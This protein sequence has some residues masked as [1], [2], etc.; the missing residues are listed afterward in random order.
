[1]NQNRLNR[2][3]TA[4]DVLRTP[5]DK[6]YLTPTEVAQLMNVS[7]IT[8]RAWAAKGMLAAEVTPGG[9][10]RFRRI[11]VERFIRQSQGESQAQPLRLL[12]LD[13]DRKLV[14]T[15]VELLSMRDL[16]LSLETAFSGFEAGLKVPL[17]SP[18][19]VLLDLLVPGLDGADTCRRLR[20][21]DGHPAPRVMTMANFMSAEVEHEMID[22]GAEF[23]LRKP[24]DAEQLL[25][26]IGVTA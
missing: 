17:F 8:V 18:D 14:N 19:I 7:P 2:F 24:I 9:H 4:T 25:A 23:C 15:L 1:M 26:L 6:P 10:R 16:P 11:D 13:V 21:G 12:V 3:E 22:A 20:L 5:D